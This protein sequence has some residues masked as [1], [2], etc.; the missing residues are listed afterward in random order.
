[1]SNELQKQIGVALKGQDW[2]YLIGFLMHMV[3][4]PELTP[5]VFETKEDCEEMEFL[6][7]QIQ[8]QVFLVSEKIKLETGNVDEVKQGIGG[9]LIG[10]KNKLIGADGRPLN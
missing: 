9:K 8:R 3:S 10:F 4:D 5:M 7:R 6:I 2:T 1:M